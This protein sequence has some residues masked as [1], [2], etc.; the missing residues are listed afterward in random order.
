MKKG[1]IIEQQITYDWKSIICEICKKYGYGVDMC[2]K[3]KAKGKV[4]QHTDE[5]VVGDQTT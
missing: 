5:P 3:N 4:E 2:R 1:Q